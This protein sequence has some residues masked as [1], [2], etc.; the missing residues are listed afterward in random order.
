MLKIGE[1]SKLA[2]VPV[3]TLRYYADLG[4]LR[5]AYVDRYS[6]YRYYSLEQLPRLNRILALKELGFSLAQIEQMVR[7]D[8]GAGELQRMMRLKH[9]ELAQQVQAEQARLE[10]V[11]LRLKQIEQEGRLPRYEVLLKPV[12]ATAI[13]GIRDRIDNY[14]DLGQLFRELAAYLSERGV[15]PG[16]A[17]AMALYYDA[18]Y[19]DQ[20]ADVEAAF[21]LAGDELKRVKSLARVTVR[22]LLP[23]EVASVI[24]TGP[25]EGITTAYSALLGWTQGHG[26]RAAGPTREIYLQGPGQGID[27]AR[28]VTEVQLPARP[29]R[30]AQPKAREDKGMEP[31]IIT[32]EAFTVVGVPFSGRI[33]HAPYEDGQ[34]NNEIGKAWDELN[35]RTAEIKHWRGPGIGLCF[36]SPE[37]G[38]PWYIAGAEVSAVEHVPAGMMAQRV[39]AQKYAVFDCTLPTI[40]QTYSFIMEQWQPASGYERADAPD[41]ELYG[42]HWDDNDPMGSPMSIYWPIK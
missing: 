21:P 32:K 39:P 9:A 11:A 34:T 38:E 17:P 1:F 29:Q 27:P 10:R 7:D 13:A 28:Y 18:E 42:E 19:R 40:G 26:G 8:L 36:G 6:G 35:A 16:R 5:P 22:A 24:Y 33:S 3:K 2:R 23:Q 20:G 14:G 37:S 30:A 15:A 25:Y 12:P 4:L 31:R 41:F